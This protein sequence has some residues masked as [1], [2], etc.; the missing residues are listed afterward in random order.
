MYE[1]EINNPNIFETSYN[2]LASNESVIRN[3]KPNKIDFIIN[4]KCKGNP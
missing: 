1:N 3:T 4:V 2:S